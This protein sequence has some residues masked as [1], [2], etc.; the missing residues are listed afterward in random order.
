M[1]APQ[2]MRAWGAGVAGGY[3][4]LGLIGGVALHIPGAE[5]LF[6]LCAILTLILALVVAPLLKPRRHDDDDG[7]VSP[8]PPPD[9]PPPPWWPEF[10]RQFR[11][12]AERLTSVRGR[13]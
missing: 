12:Y 10:E 2:R 4:A 11:D 13:T 3:A 8:P 5:L 6:G 9:D 7:G 1:S